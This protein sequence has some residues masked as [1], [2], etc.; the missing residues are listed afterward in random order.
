MKID[1]IDPPD[2]IDVSGFK[3][4]VIEV[5]SGENKTGNYVNV[6]FLARDDLRL[7]KKEYFEMDVFTDVIAFNLNDPGETI[8]GEIYLSHEQ[9]LE[10]A[11]SFNTKPKDELF[12]VLI[13]GC[14]HL[15]GYEDDTQT[16]K[17]Q[18]TNLENQYMR[19]L[20]DRMDN[21]NV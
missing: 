13:H 12:R 1:V 5:F 7:M 18:M 9:I 16:L 17:E 11:I 4:S 20:K 15:C 6:V 14:L 8:E 3:A 21:G 10:N 2:G 19:K